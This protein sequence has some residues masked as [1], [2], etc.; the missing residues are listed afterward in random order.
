MKAIKRGRK[1]VNP[2]HPAVKL[3][4]ASNGGTLRRLATKLRIS[5]QALA[6]W[7]DHIPIRHVRMISELSGI[8][9]ERLRPDIF[10]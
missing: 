4:M 7:G 1:R 2:I 10:G 8:P 9:R 5:P 6:Q 3:A